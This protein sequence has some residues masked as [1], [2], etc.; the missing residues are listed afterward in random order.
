VQKKKIQ[1]VRMAFQKSFSK[2]SPRIIVLTGPP[3]SGKSTVVKVLAKKFYEILE[4]QKPAAPLW[5]NIDGIPFGGYSSPFGA[6]LQFLKRS[7]YL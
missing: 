3:G 4:F 5:S 1:M 7:K 2:G 6:M